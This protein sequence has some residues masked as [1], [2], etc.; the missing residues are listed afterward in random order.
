MS[1]AVTIA[2]IAACG[3]LPAAAVGIVSAWFSYK[4]SEQ[5]KETLT[6]SQHTEENTNHLKDELVALT[7]KDA[8]AEGVKEERDRTPNVS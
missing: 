2:L 5:S 1:D 8:H 4:A 7:R 6:V 3:G